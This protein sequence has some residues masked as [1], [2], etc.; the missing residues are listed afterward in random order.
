MDLLDEMVVFAR[1]VELRSFSRAAR[2]LRLTTS[3]VSRSVSRLEAHLGARLLHRTTRSV[4]T[5]EIGRAVYEGCARIEDSAREVMALAGS[6]AAVPRGRLRISAPP[7]IGQV[8]LTPLLPGFLAKW[9]ELRIDLSLEDRSVDVVEEGFDVVIR[10][11]T[12]PPEGLVARPL[13]EMS[14]V[15][16]AAPAYLGGIG[17]VHPEVLGALSWLY[18][19]HGSFDDHLIL[20]RGEERREITMRGPATV[21]NSVALLGLVEAGLGIGVMPELIARRALAEGRVIRLCPDW[22]LIGSYRFR[23]VQALY[24]P[25]RNVPRKIRLFVDHLLGDSRPPI[26]AEATSARGL[27]GLCQG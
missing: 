26:P 13:F 12:Q 18:L 14:Y 9:P 24:A 2:Q 15:L 1:V 25:T 8:W 19:G 22:T 10:V 11:A 17:P 23:T 7:V 5:T 20:V 4:S 21:S 16:V 3:A 27:A 6:Y